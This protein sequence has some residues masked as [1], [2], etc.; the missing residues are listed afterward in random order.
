MSVQLHSPAALPLVNKRA[1]N[2]LKESFKVNTE[3]HDAPER[4]IFKIQWYFGLRVT[5]SASVLQDEQKFLIHF[6]LINERGL[7]IRVLPIHFVCRASGDHKPL[8]IVGNRLRCSVS[9]GILHSYSQ[10]SC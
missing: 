10:Y 1:H 7:A 9:F 4:D 5:W 2:V 3:E 8:G 6:N